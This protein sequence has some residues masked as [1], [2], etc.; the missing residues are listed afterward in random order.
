MFITIYSNN[1]IGTYNIITYIV[2][3]ELNSKRIDCL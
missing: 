2:F 3:N 1:F